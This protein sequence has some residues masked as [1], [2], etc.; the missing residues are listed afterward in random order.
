MESAYYL[1]RMFQHSTKSQESSVTEIEIASASLKNAKALSVIT[2]MES[3]YYLERQYH[4]PTRTLEPSV[5]SI[6][7]ASAS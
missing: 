2:Y 7:I 1:A 6:E 5:T 3:A 4:L